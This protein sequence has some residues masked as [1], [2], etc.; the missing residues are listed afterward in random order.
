MCVIFCRCYDLNIMS[1]S[2]S[3]KNYFAHCHIEP[4]M[5]NAFMLCVIVKISIMPVV[6]TLRVAKLIVINAECDN[7]MCTFMMRVIEV[8]NM[9]VPV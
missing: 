5:L 2:I 6:I 3:V 7:A 9:G 4:I 8:D 1:P